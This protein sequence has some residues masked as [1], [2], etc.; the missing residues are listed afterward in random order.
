MAKASI[1]YKFKVKSKGIE[2]MRAVAEEREN[3]KTE[4]KR[5][6]KGER[7]SG[8]GQDHYKAAAEA[9]GIERTRASV[10]LGARAKDDMREKVK[11]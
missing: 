3:I 6:G 9:E 7:K 2:R 10:K 8:Y 4:V 5:N 1:K 11:G